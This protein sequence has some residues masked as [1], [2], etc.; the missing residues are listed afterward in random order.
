MAIKTFTTGEV[1]T[2]AD[3]NT[4]LANS[5]LVYIK[6]QT[7]GNGVAS[8]AVTSAFSSEYENY[9]IIY[10]GGTGSGASSLGM[11]LTGSTA[12]YYAAVTG[13]NYAGGTG[14]ISDSNSASWSFAGIVTTNFCSLDVVL[15][16]PFATSRT[17]MQINGRVDMRTDGA[18]F[19]GGGWHNVS[20]SY[21][22]F[23]LSSGQNMTGGII[24]VYGFR[25]A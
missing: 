23:T 3:T 7:V 20:A 4:Y 6:Q 11:A 10:M 22:G 25:K 16:S 1:L 24:Y 15:Y 8:V 19:I 9:R 21:T 14:S 5:G 13:A 12:S 2:A 17:G 18:S